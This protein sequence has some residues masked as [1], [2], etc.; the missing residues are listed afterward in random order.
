MSRKARTPVVM[1]DD[2]EQLE[3]L[4]QELEQLE[5][6]EARDSLAVYAGLMVPS[7]VEQDEDDAALRGL[8]KLPM[9]ARYVPAEHHRLLIEGLEA[10]ERR[11]VLPGSFLARGA[12]KGVAFK[13]LMVFM[14]PGS[15][16]STY[17]SVLFP[18]WYL[19]RNPTHCVIQGSYNADLADRF[20]R[21]ARNT[22][23]S[24]EHL[25]VF[26][27]GLSRATQAQG[28]WETE[29][30][31]EYF[32]FGMKAGVTGRRSDLVVIDDAIKGRKEADSQTQRD[33]VWETYKGDV[34]TRMKP[35]C[36]IAYIATRW[37]ED[38]PAGR[39]LPPEAAGKTGWF[40]A[41]DGEWWYVISLN[42][43]IESPEEEA[44]DPLGRKLGEILW[45]EWFSEE[46]LLQER[47][48]QG[49][50]NWWALYKQMPRPEEGGILKRK[51]WRMWPGDKPPKC[52]FIFAIYDT[53]FEEDEQNDFS[54][55][56]T[57]G[58]FWFEEPPPER[59]PSSDP[60]AKW[61]RP[62]PPGGRYGAILLDMFEEKVDFP[63]LR[64]TAKEHYR[65]TKPD[66]ILVE[67]KASGH[68]LIQELRK[69]GLPVRGIPAEQSKTARAHAAAVPLEDG[70]IW[71]MDRKW[72][73]H[74]I[75]RCAS[76][77][78]GQYN[79]IGDTCVH[80]WLFLR[81]HFYL[82]TKGDAG[83]GHDD[84]EDDQPAKQELPERR[85]F[86]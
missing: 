48:T 13:R 58:I 76:F 42:A 63:T 8:E 55:R 74:V 41:K 14:P 26:N 21:R 71:Y 68:S 78:D 77:P 85:L 2:A 11:A 33:T 18:A 6:R 53:A 54:A 19:G 79:D 29:R 38:D 12:P 35:N 31:G 43:V 1:P 34:R 44:N 51:F 17:G 75:E 56:T 7:N 16:K 24:A 45:P 3:A 72:A 15:A 5:Y 49:S 50:R 61:K 40:Q 4:D 52:E 86:G 27:I 83:Q 80:A 22:F 84:D 47:R 67:K 32:S 30:G 39:I 46:M 25:S 20:G 73:E 62:T 37:H 81:S 65:L 9:A 66:L 10:L 60:L 69:A 64:K 70:C 59:K 28:E 82:T 23:S 36:A 57:W